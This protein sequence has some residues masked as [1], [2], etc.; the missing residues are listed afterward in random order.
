MPMSHLCQVSTCERIKNKSHRSIPL[1]V[2]H[3]YLLGIQLPIVETTTSMSPPSVEVTR[4]R[5]S[6][7][8]AKCSFDLPSGKRQKVD[9]PLSDLTDEIEEGLLRALR[10]LTGVLFPKILYVPG[11]VVPLD[12]SIEEEE[13]FQGQCHEDLGMFENAILVDLDKEYEEVE[14]QDLSDDESFS[15]IT[16]TP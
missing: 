11:P 7:D 14:L 4:H 6:R 16:S 3:T 15:S 10:I 2:E 9:E 8:V 13:F 12:P 5:R 1:S